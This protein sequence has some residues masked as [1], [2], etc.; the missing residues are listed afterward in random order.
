MNPSHPPSKEMK[1]T[2][3]MHMSLSHSCTVLP[4]SSN[5]NVLAAAK[6]HV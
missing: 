1:W 2:W 5:N 4:V 6:V 3:I